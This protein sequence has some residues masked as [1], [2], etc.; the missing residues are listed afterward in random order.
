[1]YRTLI[2]A[3]ALV[4]V[5]ATVAT[6]ATAGETLEPG[7]DSLSLRGV[8]EVRAEPGDFCPPDEA[9]TVTCSRQEGT[10]LVH[11]LGRVS[12]SSLVRVAVETVVCDDPDFCP[13]PELDG[14]YEVNNVL[15]TTVRFTIE[16]KGAIDFA[17]SGYTCAVELGFCD[18]RPRPYSVTGGTGIYAGAAGSG[19]VETF[20]GGSG[21]ETWT[22]SLVVPGLEFD[23]ASP[24]LIGMVDRSARAPRGQMTARVAFSVTAQD[25]VEGAVPVRCN[26]RSGTRFPLGRTWVTCS[27][28]DSSENRVAARFRV[29]VTKGL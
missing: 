18:T 28:N 4:A 7:L 21:R 3:L 24:R 8:L 29:T 20:G 1:M 16:G 26:P 27:A 25:D 17:L 19:M 2:A 23:V 14:P 12:S 13:Y 11:G 22:G 10:G 5:V 15:P 9:A 6:T